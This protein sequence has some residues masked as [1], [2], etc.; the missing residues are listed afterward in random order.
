MPERVTYPNVRLAHHSFSGRGSARPLKKVRA[1]NDNRREPS[2]WGDAAPTDV[3][4]GLM[5]ERAFRRK[6]ANDQAPR[7]SSLPEVPQ[8]GGNVTSLPG[9]WRYIPRKGEEKR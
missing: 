8:Y 9:A 2:W 3:I 4:A 1:V 5:I 6:T 7:H